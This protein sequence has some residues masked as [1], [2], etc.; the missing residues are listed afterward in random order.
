MYRFAGRYCLSYKRLAFLLLDEATASRA[1]FVIVT[2]SDWCPSVRPSARS[3]D[4]DT[5]TNTALEAVASSSSNYT[6]TA[7]NKTFWYSIKRL[8]PPTYR[9]LIVRDILGMIICICFRE[10]A[11][12]CAIELNQSIQALLVFAI[13]IASDQLVGFLCFVVELLIIYFILFIHK[14]ELQR[15][16]SDGAASA[17]KK[18]SLLRLW[19]FGQLPPRLF[20]LSTVQYFLSLIKHFI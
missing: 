4:P 18:K 1:A 9:D 11:N 15:A 17:L 10:R 8:Y 12:Y 6:A 16:T 2:G 14:F 19:L 7:P 13:F 5:M 3:S 20:V